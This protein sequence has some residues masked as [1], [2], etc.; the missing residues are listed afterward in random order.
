MSRDKGFP[1]RPGSVSKSENFMEMYVDS[2]LKEAIEPLVE[3]LNELPDKVTSNSDRLLSLEHE[4][5]KIDEHYMHCCRAICATQGLVL[6][7]VDAFNIQKEYLKI[8]N[9]E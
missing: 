9:K 4:L 1:S 5:K 2:R 6:K 3:M 8:L 7:D